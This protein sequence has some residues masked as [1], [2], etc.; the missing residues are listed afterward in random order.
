MR[1]EMQSRLT[2]ESDSSTGTESFA[3]R[4]AA[5]FCVVLWMVCCIALAR[6]SRAGAQQV[7]PPGLAGGQSVAQATPSRSK[8]NSKP[9]AARRKVTR[10]KQEAPAPTPAVAAPSPAVVL[11]Q[12]GLLTIK[13]NDSDL[14]QIMGRISAISAM[15]VDGQ[16]ESSRVYGTYGP[17]VPS[18]VITDLL[19][20]AGYNVMMIGV[21]SLGSP[22][23]LVLTAKTGGVSPPSEPTVAVQSGQTSNAESAPS[24]GEVLGPGAIAN[25]PPP[26]SEDPAVRLKQTLDRLQQMQDQQKQPQPPN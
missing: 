13:A 20:G 25:V 17:G 6:F 12:D 1:P 14:R 15:S 23:K 21:N 8:V 2:R 11:L 5:C 16:V 4:V 9:A 19:A 18:A 7:S 26:P 3:R 10:N 24:N 22:R